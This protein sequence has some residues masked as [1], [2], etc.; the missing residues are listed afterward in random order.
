[1]YVSNIYNNKRINIML[2]YKYNQQKNHWFYKISN[3]KI[4][5]DISQ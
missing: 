5:L 1:M 4:T 3:Q 2:S